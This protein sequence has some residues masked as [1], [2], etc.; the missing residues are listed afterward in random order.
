MSDKIK[1]SKD[2]Q[3]LLN[4]MFSAF[5][6]LKKLGW[7][8]AIY[9]PKDGSMCHFIEA[10]STGVHLGN[11]QGEWPKGS[12]WVYDGDM[13]PSRP[14]LFKKAISTKAPRE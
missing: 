3:E 14:I 9:C 7:N 1:V 12:F 13:W 10:G 11:Y 5:N 6:D 4:K 8:D 2:E